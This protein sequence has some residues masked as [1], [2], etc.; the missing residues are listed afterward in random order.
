[1]VVVNAAS[2]GLWLRKVLGELEGN[3]LV[4]PRLLMDNHSVVVLI[5]NLVLS[6]QSKHI[7]VKYHLVRE[8]AK[9]GSI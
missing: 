2:Q 9:Q 5:K 8:I 4:V 3:D 7:D 6:G 1:V